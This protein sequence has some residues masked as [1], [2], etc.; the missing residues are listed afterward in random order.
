MSNKRDILALF[1]L[2]SIGLF[3]CNPSPRLT[4]PP[5]PSPSPPP[6]SATP[7]RRPPPPT[8]T[9]TPTATAT[10]QPAPTSTPTSEPTAALL[11]LTG[12][13]I[14]YHGVTF[15]VDPTLG[16]TVYAQMVPWA[17]IDYVRL[18]F[19]PDG[20]CRE[21]G[22]VEVFSVQEY[23]EAF[24]DRPMPPLGAATIVRAQTRQLEFQNGSGSRAIKMYGHDVYWVNNE[25]IVYVFEGY[26][27]DEA[28]HVLVTLPIDAPILLSSAEPEEN[29]NEAAIPVPTPLPGNYDELADVMAEYNQNVVQQ[30]DL[31]TAA[32]FSPSLDALDAL[33][34]SLQIE[35]PPEGGPASGGS[36]RMVSLVPPALLGEV[37]EFRIEPDGSAWVYATY[38]YGVLRDGDW[39]TYVI[40]RDD[41]L[42]DVDDSGR[43]WLFA[44]E[45]GSSIYTWDGAADEYTPADAGW[46]PVADP[47]RLVRRDLLTDNAGRIW[48]TTG[49]DVRF[50]DG[51]RWAVFTFQDLGMTPPEDPELFTSFVPRLTGGGSLVWI[52]ECHYGGPGP[53]GGSGARW[54]DGESWHGA[55]SPAAEGCV[56]GIQEDSQGR[57][58]LGI[59][60]NLWRYD[61]A[62]DEWTQFAP[63]QP[64]EGARFLYLTNLV[65]DPA[66]EPWLLFPLCSGA[67]CGGAEVRYRLHNDAWAQVGEIS[68]NTNPILVFDGA[69]TPWLMSGGIYRIEE[70]RPVEPSIAL[71]VVQAAATDCAGQVWIAGWQVGIIGVQPATDVA[72]WVLEP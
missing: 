61:P 1:F 30:L 15:N 31:L 38:G 64:P 39:T 14:S 70:N 60:S 26:T 56:T 51:T 19:A 22:C 41:I 12:P 58:W 72:L 9:P 20:L 36:L 13:A 25:D 52:G 21:A 7:T 4:E 5:T 24:P 33:V 6:A 62:A 10:P 68:Y 43:M 59:G 29:V 35:A 42:V 18:S 45:D 16:E 34:T 28:Y 55:D 8:E 17:E 23:R 67:S 54:F 47:A 40:D 46:L 49:Q 53:M 57:V 37:K 66:D 3:A 71:I 2:L 69:G 63:P 48:L 11:A 65:I 50:F 44:G 27:S 32:D